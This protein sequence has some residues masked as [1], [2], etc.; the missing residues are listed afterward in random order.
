MKGITMNRPVAYFLASGAL[1]AGGVAASAYLLRLGFLESS[2]QLQL[3]E[4][5]NVAQVVQARIDL[6]ELHERARSLGIDPETVAGSLR[7]TRTT[8][9]KSLGHPA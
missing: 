8:L 3:R 1:G 2:L 7:E 4:A 5:K 6:A 9:A